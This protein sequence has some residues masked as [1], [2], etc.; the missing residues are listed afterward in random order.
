MHD[1]ISTLRYHLLRGL[2]RLVLR[3]RVVTAPT[4]R[5]VIVGGE[6]SA[7]RPA[8][9]S[10]DSSSHR[11]VALPENCVDFETRRTTTVSRVKRLNKLSL[12][13]TTEGEPVVTQTREHLAALPVPP[14]SRHLGGRT[15]SC[16]FLCPPNPEKFFGRVHEGIL[17]HEERLSVCVR[18]P[19]GRRLCG[20][21]FSKESPLSQGA[22]RRYSA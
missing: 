11:E 3:Q 17:A 22:P 10:R 14:N 13:F 9:S 2:A 15:W 5:D 7:F 8:V 18:L 16:A 4:L 12:I 6:A 19:K 1:D 20:A 21:P